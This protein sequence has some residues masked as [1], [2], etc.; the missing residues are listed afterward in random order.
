M[1]RLANRGHT[2]LMAVCDR[3]VFSAISRIDAAGYSEL[4]ARLPQ[5]VSRSAPPQ[6]ASLTS[7]HITEIRR[8]DV[9]TNLNIGAQQLFL[10]QM[11]SRTRPSST[12]LQWPRN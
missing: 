9:R 7:K 8:G 1:L 6:G 5:R 11:A 12:V 10:G 2:P 4:K 3:P